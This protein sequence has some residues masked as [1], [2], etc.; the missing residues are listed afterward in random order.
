[1]E[2]QIKKILTRQL[3]LEGAGVRLKRVLGNDDDSTLDP[4]LLLDHFGSNDPEDFLGILTDAWKQSLT[5]GRA[6]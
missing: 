6:K 5:C 2:R 4:F 1:L 3:T